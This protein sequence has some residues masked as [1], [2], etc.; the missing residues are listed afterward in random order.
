[1]ATRSYHDAAVWQPTPHSV[2]AQL[3]LAAWLVNIA[4]EA[5]AERGVAAVRRHH[6]IVYLAAVPVGMLQL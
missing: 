4:R 1:M 3:S 2:Q 5:W 6:H